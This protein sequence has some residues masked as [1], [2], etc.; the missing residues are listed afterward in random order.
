M[1][2]SWEQNYLFFVYPAKTFGGYPR[3]E[4]MKTSGIRWQ[5][6]FVNN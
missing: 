3:Q 1:E 6:C 4:A 2:S 5:N